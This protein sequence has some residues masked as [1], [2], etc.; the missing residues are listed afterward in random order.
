[1]LPSYCTTIG[2]KKKTTAAGIFFSFRPENENLQTMQHLA[3]AAVKFMYTDQNGKSRL[4]QT[5]EQRAR[6]RKLL[7]EG[8]RAPL[9]WPCIGSLTLISFDMRNYRLLF[10]RTVY[11]CDPLPSQVMREVKKFTRARWE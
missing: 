4:A 1:M 5:K 3:S 2:W 6:R 11:D 8:K 7:R 10:D 9:Q